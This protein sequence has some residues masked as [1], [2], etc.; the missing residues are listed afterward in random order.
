MRLRLGPFW[1]IVIQ[2]HSLARIPRL[3]HLLRA[4][5]LVAG[6]LATAL[7]TVGAPPA[8]AAEPGVNLT[9]TAPSQITAIGALGT[10]WVR[11][12]ATWPDLEPPRGTLAANWMNY[13][14]QTFRSL[15]HGSKVILAVVDTPAWETGSSNEHTPPASAGDYAAFVGA[16]AQRF[17]PRVAAY[18]IWNEEEY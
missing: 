10:H 9:G 4:S 18:E 1:S 13:Y 2:M 14:E 11:M 8:A 5:A 7:C 12:F 16:L 3:R 15:P 17:G 6:L